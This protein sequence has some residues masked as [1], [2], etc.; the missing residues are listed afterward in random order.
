[1]KVFLAN[2]LALSAAIGPSMATMPQCNELLKNPF[3]DVCE[4]N[5]QIYMQDDCRDA[6]WCSDSNTNT[7]C[8]L[9][10]DEDHIVQAGQHS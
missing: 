1:M 10:C 4:C 7:G 8:F 5:E 6:F 2:L 9:S 3:S